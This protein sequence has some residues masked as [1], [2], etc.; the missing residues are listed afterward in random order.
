MLGIA[1]ISPPVTTVREAEYDR[2]DFPRPVLAVL[3]GYLRARALDARMLLIDAKME[4][5]GFHDVVERTVAFGARVIGITAFTNEIDDAAKLA[6]MLKA[7]LPDALIVIGGVHVTALP[8][9]TLTQFPQFDVAVVGEGELTF[10]ALCEAF[11]AGQSFA[12]IPGLYYREDGHLVHT[13]A[14]SGVVMDLDTLGVPAWDLL[15]PARKHYHVMSQRG[16]PYACQFCMNPNGRKLR[17]RSVDSMI[18]EL[19]SLV[20]KGY[21]YFEFDDEIFG[22]NQKFCTALLTRM[23]ETGLSKRITFYVI[24]HARFL[25]TDFVHLLAKAGCVT[26]GF[27]METGDADQLLRIGKGLTH[28]IVLKATQDCQAA[29]I[30]VRGFFIIGHENET[31]DSGMATVRFARRLNLDIPIFGIMVPYPGT[32]VWDLALKGEGGYK[33]LSPT[34]KDYNKQVGSAVEMEQLS[35][36]K[37]ELL[38][39]I[40]YNWVFLGNLRMRDWMKFIWR[41]RMAGFSIVRHLLSPRQARPDTDK[42]AHVFF[43]NLLEVRPPGPGRS[44]GMLPMNMQPA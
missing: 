18:A 5:V 20:A 42:V 14:R 39:F 40:G 16:C 24:A 27:G 4:R 23:I 8:V 22:A 32:R 35:R 21:T 37:M 15:P 28:P 3:A 17:S 1:L 7:A 25:T 38:Q 44:S 30:T 29:G 31:W 41:Y 26:V 12:E 43:D 2:P 34:W 36:R 11:A 13:G 6:T 33:R 19:E 9:L 10:H